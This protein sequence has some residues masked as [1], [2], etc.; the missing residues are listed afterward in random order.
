MWELRAYRRPEVT[1]LWDLSVSPPQQHKFLRKL[2]SRAS[3]G[4]GEANLQA[5]TSARHASSPHSR[6]P[7]W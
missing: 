3:E 1:A 6:W 5:L 7:G 2:V 4:G